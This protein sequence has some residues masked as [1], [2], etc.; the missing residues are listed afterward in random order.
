MSLI[1]SVEIDSH[2]AGYTMLG[3]DPE[4]WNPATRETAD[5][6]LPY[7]VGRTLLDG[8]IDNLT[9]SQKKI[10]DDNVLAFL[11]K[12]TV[13]EDRALTEMYPRSIANRVTAKLSTGETISEQ[14]NDPRGHPKNPM[15][16]EEVEGK[17]RSLTKRFL[18]HG[19]IESTLDTVWN[20]EK[21]RDLSPLIRGLV[22]Q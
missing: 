22:I 11:R 7:I 18:T 8:K 1:E 15:S 21:R 6:S 5:H 9:Y 4:K 10:R 16:R 3:K 17:F 20:L 14:V 13:R 12:I 19:Q 2:E